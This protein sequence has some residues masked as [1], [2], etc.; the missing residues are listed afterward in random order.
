M[1]KQDIHIKITGDS[2]NA[3]K[4]VKDTEQSIKGLADEGNKLK[5]TLQGIFG[6]A[7][8][9]FF[10]D[11]LIDAVRNVQD[12]RVRLKG[13]TN[14]AADYAATEQFLIDLAI[15]HNKSVSDLQESF[16][17]LAV[18][19]RS[20]LTTRQQ[21]LQYL[22]GFSNVASAAGV[23]STQLKQALYGLSQ[24]L[25]QGIVQTQELNQVTE[26]LAA[27]GF[28]PALAKAF[29]YETL[30]QLRKFIGTGQLTSEMFAKTLPKAF[31]SY[32]GAAERSSGTITAT[33]NS[34]ATAYTELAKTVEKPV[35]GFAIGAVDIGKSAFG[36]ITEN[37]KAIITAI[38]LI[39]LTYAGKALGGVKQYIAGVQQSIAAEKA[40]QAAIIEEAKARELSTRAI[41]TN[42]GAK[43]QS[44]QATTAEITA[45]LAA[46][47]SELNKARYTELST[48]SKIVST[49]AKIQ[50]LQ[51]TIAAADAEM[52]LAKNE[53]AAAESA[54]SQ[55]QANIVLLAS[56][57]E[58]QRGALAQA[59]ATELTAKA[60]ADSAAANV[61]LIESNLAVVE[62]E[63]IL[64]QSSLATA[65][66]QVTK[67]TASVKALLAEQAK[68]AN[69]TKLLAAEQAKLA[70]AE[71][72]RRAA[73]TQLAEL[74]KYQALINAELADAKAKSAQAAASYQAAQANTALIESNLALLRSDIQAAT[75]TQQSTLAQIES[76]KQRIASLEADAKSANTKNLLAV[77][78][79]RLAL[80]ENEL[81]LVTARKNALDVES[82]T[83]A[84]KKA[85]A[86]VTELELKSALIKATLEQT[87]AQNALN[88]ANA[89]GSVLI[90]RLK[91]AWQSFS[92]LLGGGFGV[93]LIGLYA[94][95]E[96]LKKIKGTEAEAEKEAENWR[97]ALERVN[98][99]I[100]KLKDVPAIELDASKTEVQIEQVKQKM[101][102]LEG[103]GKGFLTGGTDL[104][105]LNEASKQYKNL[106]IVLAELEERKKRLVVAQ[107]ERIMNFDSSKLSAEQLNQELNKTNETFYEL[108]SR[109]EEANKLKLEGKLSL[110]DQ[111]ALNADEARLSA[112]TAKKSALDNDERIRG[113][114]AAVQSN[115][116]LKAAKEQAKLE[117]GIAKE[118]FTGQID[119]IKAREA[120][121]IKELEKSG[122]TE[123]QIANET[124]AIKIESAKKSAEFLKG[125]LAKERADLMAE[126]AAKKQFSKEELQAKKAT[127]KEIQSAYKTN[128]DNLNALEQQHR[129]KVKAINDEIKGLKKSEV[130]GLREIAREA[131]SETQLAAD[132][133]LEIEQ[134]TAQVRQ[135]MGQG[136]YQQAA[137][138]SKELNS[139]ALEQAKAKAAAA[140]ET[141][142]TYAVTQAQYEYQQSLRLTN[143]AL[144]AQKT[145][146]QQKADVAAAQAEIQRKAYENVGNQ[147]QALNDTLTT[148]APL[149][150]IV[151]SSQIDELKTKIEN[152]IPKE[153]VINI[154][155]TSDKEFTSI[156]IPQPTGYATGGFVGGT[157]TG[158]TVPAMLTPNEYV[159]TVPETKMLK[160][161]GFFNWLKSPKQK[162]SA[163]GLVKTSSLSS[164]SLS[165][166]S[167]TGGETFNLNLNLGN[168]T[169]AATVDKQNFDILKS[170]STALEKQSRVTR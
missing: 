24:I 32:A 47:Q 163:G 126:L 124:T 117:L 138:L 149:E 54:R 8:T 105:E 37:S 67:R 73:S 128:I 94:L 134:K 155:W 82:N 66:A 26:A 161:M 77:E 64:A 48:Q 143:E 125:E 158:D 93:A 87:A 140:K 55:A 30:G 107:N 5:S 10:T 91:G 33:Y 71:A 119:L 84:A 27:A 44:A 17:A 63:R 130:D 79:G 137:E 13:L 121:K 152:E 114:K 50:G 154:K 22:E 39:G 9:G 45:N 80:L 123:Q 58:S 112:I 3:K 31:D 120:F 51:A 74:G 151:D 14:D 65:T 135:L 7:V 104:S 111:E 160:G 147:I 96:T 70:A 101:K 49:N 110:Y 116:Q 165:S 68:G 85:Q 150:M 157:G 153:K 131:M 148:G 136:E 46:T 40:A 25:G 164:P 169:V 142:D 62:S 133:E 28:G 146:E 81:A 6:V 42:A 38:E 56:Q 83:L 166:R 29:G 18:F 129:D 16:N 59:Q 69:V 76:T 99:E 86:L 89:Q 98:K 106:K 72:T 92:A 23:G 1:A 144:N 97:A 122:K 115:A 43:L 34:M 21:T 103:V 102:E 139:L 145:A 11:K 12:L 167:K 78:I 2:T 127:L 4:A 88:G 52:V 35:A 156:P 61:R 113:A 168:Q 41:Q 109:V 53:L 108:K 132:K 15:R 170:L 95:Y 162:F 90:G 20:G 141:G 57:I 19:E 118:E 75:A 100:E 36:W 60:S 159:L